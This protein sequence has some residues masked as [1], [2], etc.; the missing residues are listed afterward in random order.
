M[1]ARKTSTKL[2]LLFI[3]LVIPF[4]GSSAQTDDSLQTK[5]AFEALKNGNNAIE[6]QLGSALSR[7]SSGLSLF[8]KHSK[9]RV[10]AI[11][12]GINLSTAIS[13]ASYDN[14]VKQDSTNYSYNDKNDQNNQNVSVLVQYI[15]YISIKAP[16]RIYWGLGPRV[17]YS[18]ASQTITRNSTDPNQPNDKIK[19]RQYSISGGIEGTLGAE[20]FATHRISLTAEY[21]A[22]L[23]YQYSHSR[24]TSNIYSGDNK[25][26]QNSVNLGL[27][28]VLFGVSVYF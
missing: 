13:S 6:F 5:T 9:S 20:W 12:M 21:G 28:D 4:L 1:S 18:H 25:N 23:I 22:N 26:T 27:L 2:V 14:L 17:G 7:R 19:Q 10:S 15:R 16:L 24:V 3:V 8:F 11:R